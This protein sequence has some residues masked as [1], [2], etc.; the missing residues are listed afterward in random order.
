MGYY[1]IKDTDYYYKPHFDQYEQD[2]YKEDKY[3]GAVLVSL[4]CI[5]GMSVLSLILLAIFGAYKLLEL[6]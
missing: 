1:R 4:C 5:S 2:M 3:K 6:M